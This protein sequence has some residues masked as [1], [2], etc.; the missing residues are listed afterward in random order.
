MIS[1]ASVNF[2]AVI[3]ATVASMGIGFFWYSPKL[4]GLQW[5]KLTKMTKANAEKDMQQAMATGLIAT[6]VSTYFL[7]VL[8]YITGAGGVREGLEVAFIVWLAT[9][10]PSE[11]HGVAWEK[12]PM[13]L[14]YINAGCSLVTYI[15]AV[16]ILQVM[17]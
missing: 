17:G 8:L 14:L 11:L 3:I 9:T 4:F 10:L 12:R 13:Q 16:S 7:A 15:V 1:I 6:L 5:M 2:V